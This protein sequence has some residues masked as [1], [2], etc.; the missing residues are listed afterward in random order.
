MIISSI[1]RSKKRIFIHTL[2]G[3]KRSSKLRT[4]IIFAF[5]LALIYFSYYFSHYI[6]WLLM[7]IRGAGKVLCNKLIQL[8]FMSIFFLLIFSNAISGYSTLFKSKEV[9]FLFKFPISYQ[10]IFFIKSLESIFLTSWAFLFLIGPFLYAYIKVMNL[11][12]N[13]LFISFIYLIPYLFLAGIIGLF[14]LFFSIKFVPKK[15]F[16]PCLIVILI[17]FTF[18]IVFYLRHNYLERELQSKGEITFFLSQLM[19]YLHIAENPYLPSYWLSKGILSFSNHDYN[20]FY[21][22]F[23]ILI[24]NMIFLGQILFKI[25][26]RTFYSTFAGLVHKESGGKVYRGFWRFVN[27]IFFFL[28][29]KSRS[30]LVKDIKIFLRDPIQWSQVLIFFGILAVY[31]GNLQGFYYHTF[32]YKWRIFIAFLNISATNL[33]VTSLAIRFV[34]PQISLEGKRFWILGIAPVSRWKILWLKYFLSSI[35]AFV[36]SVTLI[37]ISNHMLKVGKEFMLTSIFGTIICSF[38]IMAIIV[39]LSACF[40]NFKEENPSRIIGGFGGTVSL[41]FSLLFVAIMLFV[42][43]LPF[44]LHMLGKISFFLFKKY[45]YISM[46]ILFLLSSIL[47]FIFLFLGKKALENQEF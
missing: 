47:I 24:I 31:F 32:S 25:S 6:F 20:S 3:I 10:N 45:I 7:G 28:K 33:V 26:S 22:F 46:I 5:L 38:T 23:S 21:F 35:S 29:E 2:Q 14:F 19:P 9:K 4:F 1:I 16:R 34:Y 11:N 37:F 13:F 41:I 12:L 42:L 27:N 44:Q 36:I 43:V 30:F 40:P 18:A 17:L 39:G 15:T 8:F